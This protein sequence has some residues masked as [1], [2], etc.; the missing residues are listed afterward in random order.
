MSEDSVLDDFF[1]DGDCVLSLEEALPA[2]LAQ[3]DSTVATCEPCP[4]SM[5]GDAP[6][7]LSR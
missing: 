6:P 1:L 2:E 4:I 5:T 3:T 7:H